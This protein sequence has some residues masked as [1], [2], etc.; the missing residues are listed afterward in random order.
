VENITPLIEL[1]KKER[2]RQNVS[3][4]DLSSKLKISVSILKKLE[5]DENYVKE[6]Y[7]YSFFMLKSI[8]KELKIS[9]FELQDKPRKEPNDKEEKEGAKRENFNEI[10]KKKFLSLFRFASLIVLVSSFVFLSYSFKQ[11]PEKSVSNYSFSLKNPVKDPPAKHLSSPLVLVANNTIWI[12]ADID[13]KK[14][15]I[16]LKKGQSKV[17][18]FKENIKFETIGNA[19]YLT[20][21]YSGEKISFSK[22]VIHNVFVDAEGIFKD[23]YN[24]L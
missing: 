8:A 23:G 1:L 21:I 14:E 10:L 7:P 4:E 17:I 18:F 6:N 24:L 13:G 19:K 2:K 9:N 22:K 3:L 20:I 15:V 5:N 12:T 11:E 16:S